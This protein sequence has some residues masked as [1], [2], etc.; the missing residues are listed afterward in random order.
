MLRQYLAL[1]RSVTLC[2]TSFSHAWQVSQ[3]SQ[4]WALSRD[5]SCQCNVHGGGLRKEMCNVS[6]NPLVARCP[7]GGHYSAA[8]RGHSLTLLSSCEAESQPPQT[9]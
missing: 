1:T 6:T 4:G 9:A 3:T 8:T 2:L 5:D 7:S